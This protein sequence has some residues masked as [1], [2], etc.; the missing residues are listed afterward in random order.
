MQAIADSNSTLARHS[1]R[2]KLDT[3]AVVVK[4][5]YGVKIAMNEQPNSAATKASSDTDRPLSN[6]S[7]VWCGVVLAVHPV[8]R[9]TLEQAMAATTSTKVVAGKTLKPDSG[10]LCNKMQFDPIMI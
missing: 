10:M 9:P 4:K 5:L 3:S 2:L 8:D 1:L 6:G 7:G